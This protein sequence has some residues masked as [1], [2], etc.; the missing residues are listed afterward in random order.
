MAYPEVMVV[1]RK[2]KSEYKSDKDPYA[3]LR[4]SQLW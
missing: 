4:W 2:A 3:E 1:E